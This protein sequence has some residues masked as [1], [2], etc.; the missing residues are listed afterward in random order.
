MKKLLCLLFVCLLL[1]GCAPAA[2]A[3]VYRMNTVMTLEIQ[4]PD[5]KEALSAVD[6]LLKDLEETWS[7]TR[8]GSVLSALNAGEAVTPTPEQADLLDRVEALSERTGGAFAPHLRALSHAWGFGTE[9]QAVPSPDEI[10][11]ALAQD[12]WDLGG[13]LKGYAGQEAAALLDTMDIDRAL[14]N[15]GGNI[16][17]KSVV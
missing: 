5:A 8:D 9:N 4:G 7:A 12:Q 13:A 6:A 14:L 16:D 2:Q 11:A 15:L 17:R 3:T 10:A 1:T